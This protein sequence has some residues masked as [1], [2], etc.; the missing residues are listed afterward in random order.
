MNG[1][2]TIVPEENCSPPR[3]IAPW[4]IIIIIIIIILIYLRWT[5]YNSAVNQKKC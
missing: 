5:I 1:S 4:I 3:I 2:R